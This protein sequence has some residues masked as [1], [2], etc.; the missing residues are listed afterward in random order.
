M[1]VECGR[2]YLTAGQTATRG[3]RVRGEYVDV[4]RQQRGGM[5]HPLCATLGTSA[6]RRLPPI[7]YVLAKLVRGAG[8]ASP[9]ESAEHDG[10]RYARVNP[11]LQGAV[12]VA[13]PEPLVP[14]NQDHSDISTLLADM[15]RGDALA[16]QRLFPLVYEELK[17][18]ARMQRRTWL[19]ADTLN[20][21]ALV[22]E[23]YVKLV[24]GREPDWRDRAHFL[25]VAAMAMR[26]ILV[27][28]ARGRG[29]AK[30]GGHRSSIDLAKIDAVVGVGAVDAGEDAELVLALD[31]ALQRLG[32]L[33][34]RQ[35]RIVECRFFGGLSIQ[36]TADALDI[37]PASVKRGWSLAQAWLCRELGETSAS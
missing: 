19:D 4:P 33:S 6:S 21:T 28:H 26:S 32:E 37:S 17:R 7:G 31:A 9:V 27:D 13:E 11:K 5:A 24:R 16:I 12:D 29:T 3:H 34:E 30:R 15:R 14:P 25:A 18:I 23:L 2:S 22:H 20:T 8:A 10:T 35:S 36:E 1:S